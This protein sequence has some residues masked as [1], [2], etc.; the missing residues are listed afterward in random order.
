MAVIGLK[1]RFFGEVVYAVCVLKKERKNFEI[2]LR[3]YLV[4]RLANFQQPLGYS[5]VKNLPK[6]SLG[7]VVKKDLKKIYDKKNLDLSKNIREL[8]N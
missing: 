4:K 7:K 8:L 2:Q 6:N 3:N 1:D 5:F